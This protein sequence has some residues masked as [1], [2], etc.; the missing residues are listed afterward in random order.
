MNI[1]DPQ[2]EKYI[3]SHLNPGVPNELNELFEKIKTELGFEG[4]VVG[5]LEGQFLAFLVSMLSPKQILEIGTFG[6]YSSICMASTLGN[7]GHITTCEISEKHANF[8]RREIELLGL[9]DKITVISGNAIDILKT[10][11][12]GFDFVFIDAD[13]TNYLNYYQ[14]AL[15]L[16]T[17]SG[18]IALDNTLW[19][20]N[21]LNPEDSSA[22]TLAISEVNE[23]IKNDQRV[24][25]IILPIRD[26]LTLVRK[27]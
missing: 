11:N 19:S 8:A 25:S 18:I 21:V 24:R 2:I 14:R 13:K 6:G 20:G 27:K 17:D 23:F 4:M 22:D 12:P 15:E 1:T 3:I 7:Y 10:L 5:P 9:S 16:I 26:G